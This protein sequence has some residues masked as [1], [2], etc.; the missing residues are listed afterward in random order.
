MTDSS[1]TGHFIKQAPN[2]LFDSR[3]VVY[4]SKYEDNNEVDVIDSEEKYVD[5]YESKYEVD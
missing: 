3:E 1:K 5:D 2:K 4:H